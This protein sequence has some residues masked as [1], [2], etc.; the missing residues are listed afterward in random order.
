M[1][2]EIYT[3]QKKKKEFHLCLSA[4]AVLLGK[5]QM[6]DDL[7]IFGRTIMCPINNF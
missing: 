7:H 2:K 4:V 1:H 3:E 6:S 5:T